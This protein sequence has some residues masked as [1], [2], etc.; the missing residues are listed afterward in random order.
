VIVIKVARF[1]VHH[2]QAASPIATAVSAAAV[3]AAAVSAA[4]IATYHVHVHNRAHIHWQNH[5]FE[6]QLQRQQMDVTIQPHCQS[7]LQ[8]Q[9]NLRHVVVWIFRGIYGAA[10]TIDS[11]CSTTTTTTSTSRRS[12]CV[13]QEKLQLATLRVRVRLRLLL[14]QYRYLQ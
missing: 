7:W 14:L 5:E 8:S 13:L 9:S 11:R 6:N 1:K 4:V 12:C 3:S 2:G 10:A